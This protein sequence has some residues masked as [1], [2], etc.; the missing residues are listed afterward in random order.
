MVSW[1]HS[2]R[3]LGGVAA[4]VIFLFKVCDWKVFPFE[5]QDHIL[6]K[7]PAVDRRTDVVTGAVVSPGFLSVSGRGC[8][9]NEPIF[10]MRKLRPCGHTALRPGRHARSESASGPQTHVAADW[11]DAIRRLGAAVS[12]ALAPSFTNLGTA[13]ALVLWVLLILRFGQRPAWLQKLR[14]G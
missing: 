12:F 13:G 10:Q 14:S 5:T 3:Q 6:K 8:C 2:R 9:A 4:Q 1:D 11:G 7:S